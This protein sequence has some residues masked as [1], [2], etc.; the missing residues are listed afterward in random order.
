M[1]A[2]NAGR[3]GMTKPTASV[4]RKTVTRMNGIPA[5]RW[6]CIKLPGKCHRV[7]STL[8]KENFAWR[9]KR[10]NPRIRYGGIIA[11]RTRR[12]RRK[13]IRDRAKYYLI[14]SRAKNLTYEFFR[15]MP[16]HDAQ[17]NPKSLRVLRVLRASHFFL[18]QTLTRITVSGCLP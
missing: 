18:H 12:A 9:K 15:Q 14:S 2:T 1:V 3:T 5:L 6:S 7:H 10:F 13:R 16:S 8:L 11:R 17:A 4:S